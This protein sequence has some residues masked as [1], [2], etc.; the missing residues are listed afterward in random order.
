MRKEK[1]VTGIVDVCNWIQLSLLGYCAFFLL[2]YFLGVR[3]G[4]ARYSLLLFVPAAISFFIKEKCQQLWCY[5]LGNLSVCT[6][7]LFMGRAWKEQCIYGLCGVTLFVLSW[8]WKGK[9][10][11]KAF[12]ENLELWAVF[13]LIPFLLIAWIVK[14][15]AFVYDVCVWGVLCFFWFHYLNAYLANQQK[16]ILKNTQTTGEL[17]RNEITRTGK[18]AMVPFLGIGSLLLMMGGNVYKGNLLQD[19]GMI[20]YRL[21][22]WILSFF[23]TD[24]VKEEEEIQVLITPTPEV[25]P[26]E[27]VVEEAKELPLWLQNLIRLLQEIG[28]WL[29]EILAYVF[30]L[31]IVFLVCYLVWK[32]FY[33][34]SRRRVDERE[35]E[36]LVGTKEKM[37][38]EKKKF[39]VGNFLWK[40]NNEKVR[41]IFLQYI[42]KYEEDHAITKQEKTATQLTGLVIEE[43]KYGAEQLLPYYQKARYSGE[44]LTGQEVERCKKIVEAQSKDR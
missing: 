26:T 9:E 29:L 20:F 36:K 28:D 43:R 7:C 39:H 18:K 44:Q 21:L 30:I 19:I 25:Q 33:R 37:A 6:G 42:K 31:G 13:V 2:D 32:A 15:E 14:A 35:Y 1:H 10:K 22:G 27:F 12:P 23:Q 40:N 3:Q 41:K 4:C 8:V 11:E 34:S 24:Y 17:A 16:Y 5:L 38:R